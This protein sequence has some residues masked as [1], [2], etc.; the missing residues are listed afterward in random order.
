MKQRGGRLP[1]PHY[2]KGSEETGKRDGRF[3]RA[4]AAGKERKKKKIAE[5]WQGDG[6]RLEGCHIGAGPGIEH[7]KHSCT[8]RQVYGQAN[9]DS[10]TVYLRLMKTCTGGSWRGNGRGMI[11]VLVVRC[12]DARGATRRNVVPPVTVAV[13]IFSQIGIFTTVAQREQRLRP[14]IMLLC[15]CSCP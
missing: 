13:C 14:R 8:K 12:Q 1:N 3:R 4:E 11:A 5:S 10:A 9:P 6:R 15:R 7:G 2:A